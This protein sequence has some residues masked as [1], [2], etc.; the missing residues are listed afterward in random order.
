M[1]EPS[2]WTPQ[3][4]SAVVT[5]V[6][7]G[8]ALLVTALGGIYVQVKKTGEAVK[9]SD[10]EGQ[11]KLD[12]ITNLVDGTRSV[13]LRRI[14]N[15]SRATANVSRREADLLMADEAEREA[16]EQEARVRAATLGNS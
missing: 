10:V 16:D 6:F 11:K 8:L 7:A 3:M 13:L 2:A 15:L 12:T 4:V 14:A 5:A 1:A 9:V